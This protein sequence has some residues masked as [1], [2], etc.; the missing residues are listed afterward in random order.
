M[1]TNI[2]R[3]V[4]A[5]IDSFSSIENDLKGMPTV[6]L[7]GKQI[8][9]NSS[10]SQQG[11]LINIY[12]EGVPTNQ[13]HSTLLVVIGQNDNVELSIL[14]AVEHIAVSCKGTTIN[15]IFW[16]VWWSS[17]AWSKHQTSFKAVNTVLKPFYANP[18]LL[19]T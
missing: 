14:A 1:N 3:D 15:V 13:C 5:F 11:D 16:A 4:Q 17:I 8:I 7:T 9:K 10:L 12:P 6:L 18:T 2:N 19:N